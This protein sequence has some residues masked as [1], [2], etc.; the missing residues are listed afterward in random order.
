MTTSMPATRAAS[1]GPGSYRNDLILFMAIAFGVS[2]ACWFTAIGTGGSSMEPPTA[3]PFLLGA[4][5]P[6]AGA[7]VIRIRRT[8]RGETVPGHVVRSRRKTLRWVPLLMV[9][10]SGTVLLAAV[11]GDV[12]GD[13]ALSLEDAKDVLKDAG[14]PAAFLVG[15]VISGP[16][17]E[18][19]GWRGT[20]YPRMRASM[21]RFQAGLVLGVIWAVWHLPLFFI[22][23]T[24]QNDLGLNSPSGVLFTVSAI[25]MAMLVCWAYERGGVVASIAVHFA[26]NTTMVLLGVED[27]A[28]QALI[29]G[30]QTIVVVLALATS[31]PADKTGTDASPAEATP[32]TDGA[33]RV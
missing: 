20:A 3:L 13:P 19:P 4:F 21:S 18:E 8:R 26:V 15:M 2:W 32:R 6:L 31:R 28:T 5:G 24:V 9:L 25:P 10:A 27:P 12:A 11:L 30:V 29:I 7:L 14:G 33:A 16:L 22:D 1:A 17:S 23:E